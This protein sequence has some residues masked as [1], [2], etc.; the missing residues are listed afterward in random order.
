MGTRP[1]H[2]PLFFLYTR[3][4]V[5]KKTSKARAGVADL[6]TLHAVDVL[7]CLSRAKVVSR[8]TIIRQAE[9][10]PP[11]PR[12]LAGCC[13]HTSTH[14]LGLAVLSVRLGRPLGRHCG[15]GAEEDWRR[16][17]VP[18]ARRGARPRPAG[19][20]RFAI[21]WIKLDT[22]MDNYELS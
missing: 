15:L 4:G 5:R 2:F 10:S 22:T 1:S 21:G 19:I 20:F 12:A 14:L 18:P 17:G 11:S 16:G 9:R 3:S 6:Q 7:G 13:A 8:L